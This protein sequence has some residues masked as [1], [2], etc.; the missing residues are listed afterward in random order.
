M[1]EE[2]KKL[3]KLGSSASS[4]YFDKGLV[5]KITFFKNELEK[6]SFYNGVKILTDKFP[7]SILKPLCINDLSS[8]SKLKVSYEQKLLSPWISYRWISG[9]SLYE[10]ALTILNQQ[11]VLFQ[12]GFCL[13]DSRPENYW[14]Y[15]DIP[16]LVDIA[17]I[18]PLTKQNLESFRNDFL[19]HIINPLTLESNFNLSISSYYKGNL[20][21][22]NLNSLGLI[23]NWLSLTK[24]KY[25]LNFSIQDFLSQKIL[26]SSPEFIDYLIDQ[27]NV[28][29]RKQKT[30]FHHKFLKTHLKLLDKCKPNLKKVSEWNNY[31]S[32]HNKIYSIKKETEVN[33][34]L[35]NFKKD[36]KVVDLGSN[37]T[38]ISNERI[39]IKIDNDIGVCNTLQK[40]KKNGQK[41][42]SINIAEALVSESKI[43]I[44]GLNCF[45]LA[46]VAI[47]NG[48]MHHIIIDFG[49][50]VERFYMSLSNLYSEILLEFPEK[51]DPMVKLLINKK[52]EFIQWDWEGYHELYCSKYFFIFKRTRISET[53]FLLHLKSKNEE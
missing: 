29:E 48:L 9:Q 32:F 40:Y 23:S 20:N 7:K 3:I 19:K 53:R 49:I 34:F 24:L 35:S 25:Y 38:T 30:I 18:K 14:L 1:K 8:K 51:N 39:D 26:N 10:L 5:R 52:N 31:N 6:N 47:F 16:V 41:V 36:R 11:K 33:K 44:K 45:G 4:V 42:F 17:S 22:E 28:S 50:D 43:D 21:L 2:D 37:L 27:L 15:P 13:I 12:N 46:D